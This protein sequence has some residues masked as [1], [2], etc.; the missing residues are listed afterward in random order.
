MFDEIDRLRSNSFLL[1]LL[2]HYA[3]LAAP[4]R[5]VWQDRLMAMDG[6]EAVEIAKLHGELIAFAW[7][8][9]NTGNTPVIRVGAVP[10]CYRVTPSGLRALQ[11][12]QAPEDEATTNSTIATHLASNESRTRTAAK[13]LV[14]T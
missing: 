8:E 14:G 4:D 1:Q 6:V 7:V 5:L 10:A 13:S 11:Q 3:N 9:Q 12:V 2:S